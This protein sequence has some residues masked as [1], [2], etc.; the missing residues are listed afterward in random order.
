MKISAYILPSIKMKLP[1]KFDNACL[2]Q[3]KYLAKVL[4]IELDYLADEVPAANSERARAFIKKSL[5]EHKDRA[6][7]SF[8]LPEDLVQR[9]D[10]ICKSKNIPR[11][12]FLNRLLF[13]L[14]ATPETIDEIFF[15]DF[16]NW[17]TEVWSEGKHE[18]AFFQNVMYPLEQTVDPFWPIRYGLE[19]RSR[20][21]PNRTW[22]FYTTILNGHLYGLN[23]YLKDS[24]VPGTAEY[25][26]IQREIDELLGIDT[27]LSP[28]R[29]KNT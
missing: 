9:L 28:R 17:R 15:D 29:E 24:S 3:D 12:A 10:A 1:R 22:N 6:L 18:G 8:D 13:L 16:E 19:L 21:D 4:E 27:H 25:E 5:N 26:Q 11:G 20:D 7:M 14:A 23:C 2:R